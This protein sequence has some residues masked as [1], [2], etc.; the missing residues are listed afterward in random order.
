MS[1]YSL[2]QSK[3]LMRIL[4]CEVFGTTFV[5]ML[6]FEIDFRVKEELESICDVDS[7]VKVETE[8]RSEVDSR[9]KEESKLRTI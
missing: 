3:S 7:R 5:G 9:V 2:V 6:R 8:P 1:E 4:L